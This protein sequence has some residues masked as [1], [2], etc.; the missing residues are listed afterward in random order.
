MIASFFHEI[1]AIVTGRQ[2]LAEQE[3]Q[4][5]ESLEIENEPFLAVTIERLGNGEF[6]LTHYTDENQHGQRVRSPSMTFA[7]RA[8][9]RGVLCYAEP[10]AFYEDLLG[11]TVK[12]FEDDDRTPADPTARNLRRYADRWIFD[13]RERG[14]IAALRRSL[15]NGA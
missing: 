12:T 4:F 10:V 5:P 6:A 13:L 7:L 9:E 3:E 2:L 15:Q 14:Y 1:L 11:I 8:D